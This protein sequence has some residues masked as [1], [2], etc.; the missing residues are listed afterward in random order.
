MKTDE[1]ATRAEF[2]AREAEMQAKIDKAWADAS[3]ELRAEFAA[4]CEQEHT[5]GVLAR[6]DASHLVT[7]VCERRPELEAKNLT[8]WRALCDDAKGRP[9]IFHIW[10]N[11]HKRDAALMAQFD[12]SKEDATQL[13]NLS[14][15]TRARLLLDGKSVP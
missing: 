12:L 10:L 2:E 11:T 7:C 9:M 4:W 15:S 5:E 1:A 3:P 6:G 13:R 8:R 14:R